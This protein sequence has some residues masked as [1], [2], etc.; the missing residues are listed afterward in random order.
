MRLLVRNVG[1]GRTI[2]LSWQVHLTRVFQD[3]DCDTH[4]APLDLAVFARPPEE[5]VAS[6][7]RQEEKGIEFEIQLYKRV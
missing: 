2:K 5:D 7:E 4:M 1:V 3:F 6:A